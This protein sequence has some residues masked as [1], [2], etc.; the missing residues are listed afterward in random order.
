MAYETKQGATNSPQRGGAFESGTTAG[1]TSASNKGGVFNTG[2]GD[3]IGVTDGAQRGGVFD[4][5]VVVNGQQGI[6]GPKGDP[7]EAGMDGAPGVGVPA[8]G[9]TGQVLAKK[10]GADYDTQWVDDGS[11]STTNTLTNPTNTL[12]ST[13]NGVAAT[14]TVV[15]T[16]ALGVDQN[17]L[18]ATVNGVSGSVTLPTIPGTTNTLTNTVNTITSTVDG[19]SASAPAVNTVV[20][21]VGGTQSAPTLTTTV[22][23]VESAAV[24]LPTAATTNTINRP[25]GSNALTSTVNGVMSSTTV[26][27]PIGGSVTN[28]NLVLTL[29][30]VTSGEI[31]LPTVAM[32]SNSLTRS[33]NSMTSVVGTNSSTTSIV[34]TPSLGSTTNNMTVTVNGQTSV[35]VPIINS[36]SNSVN[37]NQLVTSVNG[38]NSAPITIPSTGITIED[39]GVEEGTNVTTLDFEGDGVSL[40]VGLG[41]AQINIPGTTV[42]GNYASDIEFTG[43]VVV[44]R[45][46]DVTTVNIPTAPFTG[47]TNVIL[48]E[49]AWRTVTPTTVNGVETITVTD[50]N[51]DA[52]K[53]FAGLNYIQLQL[54]WSF[55]TNTLNA[56]AAGALNIDTTGILGLRGSV[57]VQFAQGANLATV[58]TNTLNALIVD[59]TRWNIAGSW[60]N[61]Y[62]A[63]S[64][65]YTGTSSPFTSPTVTFLSSNS[66]AGGS[67]IVQP[68]SV[69]FPAQ[70]NGAPQFRKITPDDILPAISGTPMEGQ[71]VT[72]NAMGNT[73]QWSNI[74]TPVTTNTLASAVNTLTSTVNGVASSAPA[75]NTVALAAGTAANTL[76]ASVNGVSSNDFSLPAVQTSS[77]VQGNGIAVT[78]AT[79]G[80]NTA[81]TVSAALTA[82]DSGT[83]RTGTYSV[84]NLGNNLTGNVS[85]GVLTIDAMG[86]GGEGPYIFNSLSAFATQPAAVP[87]WDTTTNGTGTI[88]LTISATNAN[89][90]TVGPT[91]TINPAASSGSNPFVVASSRAGIAYTG[92]VSGTGRGTDSTT[93]PFTGS[94]APVT[95]TQTTYVPAFF[96]QT[97]NSTQPTFSRTSPNQT[98]GNASGSQFTYPTATATTQYNWIA[99]QLPKSALSLKTPFG[100]NPL[101]TDVSTTITVEGQTFNL[102]GWTRLAVGGAS[103]VVIA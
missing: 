88:S 62:T 40:L 1:V 71:V 18:T 73:S 32:P 101:T 85:N 41:G 92:S 15:N 59:N 99:T 70:V 77:V 19:V 46:D 20:N 6:P 36:L 7:G 78:S 82:Q 28:N 31:P 55:S 84:I 53:F 94:A 91:Y 5:V 25:T 72:W 63:I 87:F 16:V 54:G 102:F 27:D 42:N 23:G 17:V 33:G 69:L 2:S 67:S 13:V 76:R 50:N 75:V 60:N 47:L 57:T 52:N 34:D 48:R 65:A 43:N 86:G 9:T 30:G 81:Y 8:G 12:T 74:P 29:N 14:A 103:T 93:T 98:S 3:I 37:N 83:A 38:V 39:H 58:I 95:V 89:G 24:N 66:W 96:T 100:N 68:N 51:E 80:V 11:G 35:S 4:G 26:V 21:T 45:V 61:N 22:N 49:P 10:T 90:Y 79:V 44:S 56:T 64:L 97:A